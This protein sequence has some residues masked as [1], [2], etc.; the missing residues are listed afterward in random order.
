VVKANL[1]RE[2][3]T[4]SERFEPVHSGPVFKEFVVRDRQDQ[5]QSLLD[6]A[7]AQGFLAGVPL[8]PI[9]SRYSDC[10]LFAV[11]EKRTEAE[12]DALMTVLESA[13]TTAA[14][15]VAQTV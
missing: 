9:D 7:T 12:L 15:P 10:F 5:V 6:H 8:G 1:A 3:F 11:T 14:T 4:A 13:D 2:R